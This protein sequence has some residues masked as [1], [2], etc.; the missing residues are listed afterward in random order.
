MKR[1]LIRTHDVFNTLTTCLN[2]FLQHEWPCIL[3][4]EK[5]FLKRLKSSLARLKMSFWY[6]F[7]VFVEER[8]RFISMDDAEGAKRICDDYPSTTSIKL[9]KRRRRHAAAAAPDNPGRSLCSGSPGRR[10]HQRQ[11][12]SPWRR[13]W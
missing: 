7:F 5:S 12:C 6:L 1:A 2:K 4:V 10:G 3:G 11:R 9:I 13:Q 8:A